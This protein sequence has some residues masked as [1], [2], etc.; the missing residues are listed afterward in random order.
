MKKW[1]CTK[2]LFKSLKSLYTFL[3]HQI[4]K[5]GS[6]VR[7]SVTCL[8]RAVSPCSNVTMFENNEA[9][10]AHL[11]CSGRERGLRKPWKALSPRCSLTL[12]WQIFSF[13]N[14]VWFLGINNLLIL[15][16]G[17]ILASE[18]QDQQCDKYHNMWE[19]VR[20]ELSYLNLTF[21]TPA[22][23]TASSLSCSRLLSVNLSNQ[24]HHKIT[25]IFIFRRPDFILQCLVKS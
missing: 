20:L 18:P 12:H 4:N 16:K 24:G 6:W 8:P 1:L 14:K 23:T 10:Q 7:C 5:I 22:S 3:L 21:L 19:A 13:V 2:K 15:T 25:A 9:W 17:K 11:C